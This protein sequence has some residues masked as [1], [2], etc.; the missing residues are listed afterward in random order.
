MVRPLPIHPHPLSIL[1]QSP[2]SKVPRDSARQ[3]AGATAEQPV[4]QES[5]FR[6]CMPV[7]SR[8]LSPCGLLC[9]Q[10][11]PPYVSVPPLMGAPALR[12]DPRFLIHT[13][14]IPRLPALEPAYAQPF[15]AFAAGEHCAAGGVRAAHGTGRIGPLRREFQ[16][17]ALAEDP[18]VRCPFERPAAGLCADLQRSV[19]AGG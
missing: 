5:D 6:R 4:G 13:G 9:Q 16:R 15:R 7:R 8:V 3:V 17:G 18:G 12:S 11:E 1:P 10:Q 14:G 19:R 2:L